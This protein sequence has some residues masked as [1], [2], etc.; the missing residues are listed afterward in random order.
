MH[1]EEKIMDG[2]PKCTVEYKAIQR[3][4]MESAGKR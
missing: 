3:K 1:K 4:D 2:F